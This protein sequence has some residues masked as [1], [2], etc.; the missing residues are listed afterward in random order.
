[1]WEPRVARLPQPGNA[2]SLSSATLKLKLNVAAH[3][4]THVSSD[5]D[6]VGLER[7]SFQAQGTHARVCMCVCV[8]V[9]ERNM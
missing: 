4:I 7:R 2:E 5:A 8:R 3:A 1:M 9:R 6:D